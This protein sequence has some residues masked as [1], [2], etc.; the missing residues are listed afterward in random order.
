MDGKLSGSPAL[1]RVSSNPAQPGVPRFERH[2]PLPA[3]CC[4]R[5][6]HENIPSIGFVRKMCNP[7]PSHPPLSSG[8]SS[9]AQQPRISAGITR[10][11]GSSSGW[12][13]YFIENGRRI[14]IMK[15]NIIFSCWKV[16]FYGHF[17]HRSL[18]CITCPC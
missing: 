4:V 2:V 18:V 10:T 6:I 14:Y 15:Y 16:F 7:A 12:S 5:S 8:S 11:K 1:S 9:S 17:L 3:L 13:R